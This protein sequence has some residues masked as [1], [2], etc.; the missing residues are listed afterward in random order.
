MTGPLESLIYTDCRENQG[1]NPS[2]G[3]GF[4]A[5]SPGAD[6]VAQNVVQNN[7]LYEAPEPWTLQSRPVDEYPPSL[8]HFYADGWYATAAGI[9]LG[10]EAS[11]TREGNHLTHAVLTTDPTAYGLYRAAQLF[12]AS[13]WATQPAPTTRLPRIEAGWEP[14]PYSV[15]RVQ[16]FVNAAPNGEAMLTSLVSAAQRLVANPYGQRILFVATEIEPVIQWIVATT[17]LLPRLDAARMSFRVF[18]P[19]PEACKHLIVAVHPGFGTFDVSV[20]RNR[21]FAVFDLVNHEF[22]PVEPTP[23]ARRWAAHFC[24][25]DPYD[26][27][28]M[29]EVAAT[30]TLADD[31]A[32]IVARYILVPD[33]PD[34]REAGVIAR[35]LRQ[36][37]ST[38]LADRRPGL[39]T[40][41]TQNGQT[42]PYDVLVDLDAVA[43]SGE[44][45]PDVSARVRLTLIRSH[46]ELTRQGNDRPFE[47]HDLPPGV[48]QPHHQAEAEQELAHILESDPVPATVDQVL[49][50]ARRLRLQIGVNAMPTAADALADHWA[51]HPDADYDPQSWP[52]PAA[53]QLVDLRHQKLSHL[54]ADPA[55]RYWVGD[56]WWRQYLPS[57]DTISG[58]LE[59]VVVA[60]A[61]AEADDEQRAQLVARFLSARGVPLTP[62]A[63]TV[64]SAL[65]ERTPAH[66]SELPQ[67]LAVCL[68]GSTVNQA[69]FA[70]FLSQ[71]TGQAPLKD[72]DVHLAY[73]LIKH[74]LMQVDP[75]LDRLFRDI[76]V[77]RNLSELFLH[78][79]Q[80]PIAEVV[81]QLQAIPERVIAYMSGHLTQA[82]LVTA[83]PEEARALMTAAAPA[84]KDYL[85]QLIA[86]VEQGSVSHVVT[87]FVLSRRNVLGERATSAVLSAVDRWA[88][89]ATEPQVR[90]VHVA[91][92]DISAADADAWAARFK[93]RRRRLPL[94]WKP[95]RRK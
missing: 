16:A 21:G 66:L 52:D 77:V 90:Y 50:A 70:E 53:G 19:K 62:Y 57:I 39:V 41:L 14:G 54:A 69:V 81:A 30:T 78:R 74:G 11:G 33:T 60:T 1:L 84:A 95:L 64:V 58:P 12:G 87:A 76:A 63:A 59:E 68:P 47:L 37:P 51:R 34:E 48:W 23:N 72:P 31:D 36:T 25:D 43:V 67:I 17:L 93:P 6:R 89:R 5:A 7:L 29:V 73:S 44:M 49:R 82:M 92:R 86:A 55:T 56:N 4:Q 94:R 83:D 9:Y 46:L 18:T 79:R 35:W 3:F 85:R 13:F 24:R 8:A 91:L 45:P 65:W 38:L 75:A 61:M 32:Y 71:L 10:R 20:Q 28:D 2:P 27:M 40:V 88:E 15:D 42:W 26:A 80:P 22:T